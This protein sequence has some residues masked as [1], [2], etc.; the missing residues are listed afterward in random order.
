ML[1]S[2]PLSSLPQLRNEILPL[3]VRH[4]HRRAVA[5]APLGAAQAVFVLDL[6]LILLFVLLG[7]LEQLLEHLGRLEPRII[8]GVLPLVLRIPFVQELEPGHHGGRDRL[9][10]GR[11]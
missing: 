3:L 10:P 7:P 11:P 8:L 1:Y 4:P 2:L 5:D 6:P 9:Q